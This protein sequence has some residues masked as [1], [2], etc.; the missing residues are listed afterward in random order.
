VPTGEVLSFEGRG[1]YWS[2]PR[3]AR[4][5]DGQLLLKVLPLSWLYGGKENM[6]P[7]PELKKENPLK[8]PDTGR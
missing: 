2:P 6:K 7:T 4:D 3:E 1:A 8:V 5:A